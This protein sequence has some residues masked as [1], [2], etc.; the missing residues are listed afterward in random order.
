LPGGIYELTA[1]QVAVLADRA[2]AGGEHSLIWNGR[3]ASGRSMPSGTYLVRL[4][5]ELGV[6]VRKVSLIRRLR[7]QERDVRSGTRPMFEFVHSHRHELQL[8]VPLAR[9]SAGHVLR[10][11]DIH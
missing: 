6:E 4:E 9:R 7:A 5:T 8:L 3:D 2:F 10:D 11:A 1:K